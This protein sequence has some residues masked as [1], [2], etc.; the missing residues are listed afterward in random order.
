[1]S[2]L[3]KRCYPPR[4]PRARLEELR[5]R[6]AAKGRA[7][8]L[9]VEVM[10]R[11]RELDSLAD[12]LEIC[13]RVG[14]VQ[15]VI[16]FAHMHATSDG[17]FHRRRG[18]RG[19]A[20]GRGRRPRAGAPFHIHFADIS[21]VNR[22]EKAHLPYDGGTLRAGPLAQALARNARPAT[23]IAGSP[24]EASNQTI[25]TVLQRAPIGTCHP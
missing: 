12:V 11:V 19:S 15:S 3:P 24:D 6:L 20:G 14:W 4:A 17:G 25:R 16:D 10:G 23:V 8:P 22:N 7:V 9:G 1:M 13:R 21:F 5:E 18:I 2:A